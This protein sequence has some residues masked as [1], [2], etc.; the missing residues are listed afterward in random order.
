M[1]L[2]KRILAIEFEFLAGIMC[3]KHM[4]LVQI[5]IASAQLLECVSKVTPNIVEIIHI[6][7][8]SFFSF[9]LVQ[10]HH[11]CMAC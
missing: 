5:K 3:F 1:V 7:G 9:S 4:H 2:N 10:G 6:L 11:I 8:L